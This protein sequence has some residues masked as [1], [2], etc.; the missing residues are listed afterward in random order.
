MRRLQTPLGIAAAAL[1][2][3]GIVVMA[4]QTE[5]HR[6][7]RPETEPATAAEATA[8]DLVATG[9]RLLEERRLREAD[10][11]FRAAA[12]ADADLADAHRGLAAVAYDQGALLR[13]VDHLN[14]VAR[15]DPQD[16]RPH[17]M[18]G[19]IWADLDRREEAVA[20]YRTALDRTLSPA[21]RAEVNEEL[22][23]QLLELGEAAAALE[24][25]PS[26][27][28]SP[29]AAAVRAEA[30]WAVAGS[31]AALAP[32][33][34]AM[35]AHPRSARL[36]GLVGRLHVDRGAWEEAAE[37]LVAALRIDHSDL[38]A[39]QALASAYERLGRTAAAASVRER[40]DQAQKAFERLTALTRD[41]NDRPW[42]PAVRLELAATCDA[43]GK[44]DLAAMWR[45]SAAI[46]NAE[47]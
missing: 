7:Q 5:R 24:A 10:A 40:R 1:L 3:V 33:V 25:L 43:L 14:E 38:E 9:R 47:R 34:A 44:P 6:R 46:C 31:E 18:I 35:K 13:A 20:A 12:D 28:A 16:G 11:A 42:D 39:L 21:A 17:R 23:E 19:T 4:R 45:E 22:A 32:A 27:A 2:I 26:E 36:A 29:L 8:R 37:A 15:I 41:A 30:T